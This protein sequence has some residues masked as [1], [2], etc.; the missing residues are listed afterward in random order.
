M[1]QFAIKDFTLIGVQSQV[2]IRIRISPK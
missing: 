2:I 1:K